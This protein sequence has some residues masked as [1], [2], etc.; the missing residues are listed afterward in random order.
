M[1]VP[2]DLKYTKEH[3]WVKDLGEGTYLIGISDYAQEQIG[4]VSYVELPEVGDSFSAGDVMCTVE[5]FKAASEIYAPFDL[6]ITQVNEAL[7]DAPEA[8]NEDAYKAYLVKASSKGDSELLTAE[9][10]KKMVEGE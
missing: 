5:S 1:N 7:E 2:K 6:T 8:V 10:Y 3:E 4:D 9:D